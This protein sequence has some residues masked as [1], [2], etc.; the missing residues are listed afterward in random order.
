MSWFSDHVLTQSGPAHWKKMVRGL[1][2]WI[3]GSNR[4]ALNYVPKNK[5]ADQL[6]GLLPS[7]ACVFVFFMWGNVGFSHVVAHISENTE[8]RALHIHVHVCSGMFTSIFFMGDSDFYLG[9]LG[10]LPF[11]F[12]FGKFFFKDFWEKKSTKIGKNIDLFLDWEWC[13]YKASKN[14]PK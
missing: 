3:L 1:I 9:F 12:T 10:K 2:S 7:W 8:L 11:S 6:P 5:G 13:L 4:I 14:G